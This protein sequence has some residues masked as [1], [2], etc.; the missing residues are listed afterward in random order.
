MTKKEY[1]NQAYYLDKQIK[2]DLLQLENLKSIADSIPS[3]CFGEKVK[4]TRNFDPPFVRTLE[5][6]WQK[7]EEINVE[8]AKLLDLKDEIRAVINT[9]ANQDERLV[10]DYRYLLF[11]KLEEIAAEMNVSMSSVK[12]WHQNGIKNLTIPK[13]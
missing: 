5:K 2:R 6:I 11:H 8:I 10:L 1:L 12:R 9:L 7:E 4:S 13:S 3:P